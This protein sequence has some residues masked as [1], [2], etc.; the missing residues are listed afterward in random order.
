MAETT[1]R[2]AVTCTSKKAF[3]EA[4]VSRE[5][6]T[7]ETTFAELRVP[8]PDHP[9]IGALTLDRKDDIWP[10]EAGISD[11]G[12]IQDKEHGGPEYLTVLKYVSIQHIRVSHQF[13]DSYHLLEEGPVAGVHIVLRGSGQKGRVT[14]PLA[15]TWPIDHCI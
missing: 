2:S 14:P 10:V 4:F 1:V 5:T 12:V 7:F 3:N 15:E 9:V 13:A 11:L 6:D 8:K